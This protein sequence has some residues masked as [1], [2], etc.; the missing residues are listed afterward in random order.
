MKLYK[1]KQLTAWLL[2]ICSLSA[3]IFFFYWAYYAVYDP[4]QVEVQGHNAYADK[5]YSQAYD[6]FYRSAQITASQ[7]EINAQNLSM[8]YRLAAAA[9]HAANNY[10]GARAMLK[11]SLSHNPDNQQAIALE[12]YM[13][14]QKQGE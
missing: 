3:S 11:K 4:K 2:I 9:A 5:Q 8:R 10:R 7:T 13:N 14:T 6:Y 1:N 12:K